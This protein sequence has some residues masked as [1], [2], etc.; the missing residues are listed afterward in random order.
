MMD[1]WFFGFDARIALY[2]ARTG[3]AP[4]P[5]TL[6]PAVLQIWRHACG[7][8]PA[9]FQS[10]MAGLN[11]ARRTLGRFIAPYDLW[12]TPT[13]T[14]TAEPWGNYNLGRGDVPYEA[15]A[16]TLYRPIAQFT[17]PH[18]IMG[19]PAISLPLA[20]HANGLPIG[21]QL[22]AHPAQEHLLLQVAAQLEAAQPWA[23][24]LPPL[25]LSRVGDGG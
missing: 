5:D 4:G 6:E 3:R 8:T 12:L 19:T 11:A 17:L 23:Q 21:V 10:A 18:N 2:A 1:I 15:I 25:H 14:R 20:M 7:L 16:E 13:T 24:R 22:G 9:Q